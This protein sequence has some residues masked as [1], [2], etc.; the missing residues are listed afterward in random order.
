[1]M[2][3]CAKCECNMQHRLLPAVLEWDLRKMRSVGVP[4][5]L[6][7]QPRPQRSQ[8]A[9]QPDRGHQKVIVRSVFNVV[10]SLQ[11]EGGNTNEDYNR[12]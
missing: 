5:K 12:M 6:R 9:S 8:V 4:T 1:M 11:A 7:V 10:E 3:V 2:R